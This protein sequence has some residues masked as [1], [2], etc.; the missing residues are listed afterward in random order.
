M[1]PPFAIKYLA[2]FVIVLAG[3]GGAYL[4]GRE[5]ATAKR[6]ERIGQ[7]EQALKGSEA[8]VL[9]LRT[10]NQRWAAIANGWRDAAEGGVARYARE[11]ARLAAENARLKRELD[12]VYREDPDAAAWA[13]TPVPAAVAD[14]LRR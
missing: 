1:L 11:Q 3:L 5:D 10:E 13:A 2:A 14:R 9:Q 12:E 6:S 7:L 4:K 8:A